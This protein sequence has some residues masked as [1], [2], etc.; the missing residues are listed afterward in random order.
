MQLNLLNVECPSCGNTATLHV[1]EWLDEERG[2]VCQAEG[3]QAV[4]SLRVGRSKE[5][6]DEVVGQMEKQWVQ[7]HG[8]SEPTNWDWQAVKADAGSGMIKPLSDY[9]YIPPLRATLVE[10]IRSFVTA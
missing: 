1:G 9:R 6:S 2:V 10:K 5:S 4:F 7:A 8:E 3:C